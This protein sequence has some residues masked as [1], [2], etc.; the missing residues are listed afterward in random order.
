MSA[1]NVSRTD[2]AHSSAGC[3][4]MRGAAGDSGGSD[5]RPRYAKP[6][7]TETP[8]TSHSQK[9]FRPRVTDFVAVGGIELPRILGET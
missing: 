3:G 1:D 9:G 2:S 6:S 5:T 7:P 4:G 8:T